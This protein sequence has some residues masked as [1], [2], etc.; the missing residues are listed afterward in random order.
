V[1]HKLSFTK[2]KK[3]TATSSF[4]LS[5]SNGTTSVTWHF[6]LATPRPWNIFNL[7][8]S[9]DK[10]MGKDF[11]DGLAL[12]KS[13]IEK[14]NGNAPAK[15][16]AIETMN[17]PGASFAAI[18][19]QVK[20]TDFSAFYS[21][22]L[23]IIFEEAQKQNASPGTASSLFYNWDEKDQI[24]DVAAAYPVTSGSKFENNIIQLVS[25]DAS[26]AL[27]VDFHGS[28]DKLPDAYAG[29]RKYINENSLKQKTPSI[30]QYITG[31]FNEKD[32]AKWL[33]K[34]V[35]LVE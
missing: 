28:Y 29:L 27:Y 17:F 7:F 25:I 5:E 14:I 9:L 15:T 31:P 22:N 33:T 11:E 4:T 24:A 20:W 16:Y 1:S 3:G 19:Q 34:V 2:P 8:S 6:E 32:T 10:N 35:F 30:E 18:R 13:S 26:K 21:Q 23:P 12:L